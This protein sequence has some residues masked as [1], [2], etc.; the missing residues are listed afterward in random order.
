MSMSKKPNPLIVFAKLMDVEATIKSELDRNS[1]VRTLHVAITKGEW[2]IALN[3]TRCY[4]FFCKAHI[5]KGDLFF[6]NGCETGYC[7]RCMTRLFQKH[8]MRML[9][10]PT[11]IKQ[12]NKLRRQLDV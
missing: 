9:K 6:F 1:N 5:K 10:K 2:K 12:Y 11:W 4:F 7:N 3:A 8:S